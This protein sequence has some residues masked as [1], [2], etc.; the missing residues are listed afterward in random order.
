MAADDQEHAALEARARRSLLE[1]G[2]AGLPRPPWMH[3][4]QPPSA[5]ELLR[6]ALWRQGT[7]NDE[8]LLLAA[9]ALLTTARAEVDQLEAALL[10]TARALGVS[11]PRISS[12]MGLRS[13]QAAQQRFER[14]T[15]RVEQ[16]ERR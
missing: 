13:P 10:F 3:P 2:A 5:I 1:A 14:V 8:E 16:Y 9:A 15:G 12:A 4:N 7:E 11:W 6:F